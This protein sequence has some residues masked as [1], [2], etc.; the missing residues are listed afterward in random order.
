MV[1]YYK[2]NKLIKILT[3]L[4][5]LAGLLYCLYQISTTT[6]INSWYEIFGFGRFVRNL[7]G[8]IIAALSVLVA[9]KP[10]DPLPW[11]WLLLLAF[12]ILLIIFSWLMGGVCVLIGAMAGLIDDI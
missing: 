4:G 7:L 9:L 11:H 8:M 2:H 1:K 12:G 10:D 5:G 3:I 6:Q